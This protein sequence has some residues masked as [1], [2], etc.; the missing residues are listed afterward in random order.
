M[1]IKKIRVNTYRVCFLVTVFML[2]P[3]VFSGTASAYIVVDPSTITL[4]LVGSDVVTE[5]ITIRWEGENR[6]FFELSTNII[7]DGIGINVTYSQN[8]FSLNPN[9]EILIKMVINTSLALMPCIYIITTNVVAITE[10]TY[11]VSRGAEGESHWYPDD[12]L[13]D[14]KPPEPPDDDEEPP[15]EEDEFVSVIYYTITEDG[16]FPFWILIVIGLGIIMPFCIMLL[17]IIIKRRKKAEKPG[18]KENENENK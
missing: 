16:R 2:F 12:Y 15:D 7:P 6:G 13:P 3:I 14:Y 9:T 5:D 17:F 4:D 10:E 1:K 11:E 18:E 8:S